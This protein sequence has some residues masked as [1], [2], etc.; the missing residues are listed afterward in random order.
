MDE[1]INLA[2]LLIDA[3]DDNNLYI[4]KEHY[5]TKNY[6]L[7]VNLLP[8]D[9]QDK[10]K[11]MEN[12]VEYKVNK[13]NLSKLTTH[14]TKPKLWELSDEILELEKDLDLIAESDILTDEEKETKTKELFERFL[15]VSEDFDSKAETVAKYIKHQE[16]LAEARKIEYQR[17]RNLYQSAENQANKM[18]GYLANHLLRHGRTKLETTTVKL[19]LRKKQ[20]SIEFLKPVAELPDEYTKT[21]IKPQLTAIRKHIQVNPECDWAKFSDFEQ[22]SLTIR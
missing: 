10:L 17:L 16:A 9:Y 21:E 4:V 7:A 14:K 12:K 3:I 13:P 6:V 20:P 2:K 15:E 18:R 11:A 22:Y 8:T 5:V 19:S 1:I